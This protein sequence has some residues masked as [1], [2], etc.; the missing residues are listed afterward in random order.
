[1]ESGRKGER[2]R[3][4]RYENDILVILFFFYCFELD[5][6]VKFRCLFSYNFLVF[7]SLFLL[8]RVTKDFF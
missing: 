8:L 3:K 1:M 4:F 5:E 2:C 6:K 7:L